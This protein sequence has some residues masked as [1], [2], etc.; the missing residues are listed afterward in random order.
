MKHVIN[1]ASLSS[2]DRPSGSY[3]HDEVDVHG[4]S[5]H[6]VEAGD[7]RHGQEA[8]R[9]HLPAQEEVSLQVVEAEVVL[10]A[11]GTAEIRTLSYSAS[12][13]SVV[14]TSFPSVFLM[15]LLT[16][17]IT[18]N[19][20]DVFTAALKLVWSQRHRTFYLQIYLNL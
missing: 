12:L 11:G 9:I 5:L 19:V 18:L 20:T 14:Y 4:Q 10:A 17:L 8:L 1:G 13:N 7:Q 16:S 2:S 6:P 3:L 15:H